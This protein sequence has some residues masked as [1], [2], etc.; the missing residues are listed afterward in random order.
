MSYQSVNPYDG[1]VLQSFEEMTDRQ[2]ESAL[3]TAAACFEI[4]NK[5]SYG[6]RAVIVARAAVLMRERSE[7]FA[8]SVTLEMG[9]LITQARG[10][11]ELSADIIDYYAKNA[12]TF[13]APEALHPTTG[14]AE[15]QNAA[16]GV[17]FGV[18]PW[19]FPYYQ[20]ARFA[21]P[22][23][24]AGNVVMVKHARCVPQCAIAFEKLWLDAGAPAGAY[25]NLLISYDQVNRVIDDPRIKGIALTGSV[26]A[27]K[28]VAAR[29]GLNLK[30]STMEL[31]G[32]DAFIVLE[33]ADLDKTVEWAVWAKMN[34]TGQCCVAAKRFIV[35]E[36]LADRFLDKFQT[37]LAKLKPGN[38]MDVATTLG[39]LSTEAALIKLLAQVKQAVEKGA[40]LV[41]GG[42]RLNRAGA[43]M[44]PTILSHITPDNPAFRDEFFG[45]V[46][47]FFRVKD[48]NEAI[49]LANDSEF[50]LGG[51]IFTRDVQRGKR[52]ASHINTGMVFINHPTW[53]T[54]DLPFGG[55]KN[56]GYGRELSSMGIQEFVNKKLVRTASIDAP[57]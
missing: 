54:P 3:A 49:A 46:A 15:I 12:E 29:A 55:I 20:L 22:N 13:L 57:A 32:S 47:L 41:M 50:G 21:A 56:S 10:E 52:L 40:K 31:G 23:L 24:M 19:N 30:K 35:V 33:D 48:E 8:R 37:A 17:L 7:E 36:A 34:N 53:T 5:K 9:K 1:K 18:E 11:V 39:P 45:P 42:K 27:G 14:E 25:T 38:P 43:F 4:W 51:S 28:A 16:L 26:E 2:L 44:E 6:E